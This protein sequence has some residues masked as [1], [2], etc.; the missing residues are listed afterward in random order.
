[1]VDR[2]GQTG[3][4]LV[5]W[6]AGC[7]HATSQHSGWR[8]TEPLSWWCD[9]P[10]G[11]AMMLCDNV[12]GYDADGGRGSSSTHTSRT[13]VLIQRASAFW[14]G[15]AFGRGGLLTGTPSD[16]GQERVHVA[17]SRSGFVVARS[18]RAHADSPAPADGQRSDHCRL[19]RRTRL[20]LPQGCRAARARASWGRQRP[21]ARRETR[22][23]CRV[24]SRLMIWPPGISL[25][26][27]RPKFAALFR[28]LAELSVIRGR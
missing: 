14:G 7:G 17:Q 27:R 2:H 16:G 26:P 22:P 25:D 4:D 9:G 8:G 20:P 21:G 11:P 24:W 18:W 12:P 13:P 5:V 10:D 3:G 23:R 28:K 15:R 1:M 6:G 19:G